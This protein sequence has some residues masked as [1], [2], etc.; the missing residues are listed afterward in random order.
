VIIFKTAGG[1]TEAARRLVDAIGIDPHL[2][3]LHAVAFVPMRVFN[4]H[5]TPSSA[6]SKVTSPIMWRLTGDRDA[7]RV[8]V[9]EENR[10]P[11]ARALGAVGCSNE[12]QEIGPLGVRDKALV[13]ID[14]QPP[15]RTA[16]VRIPPG[17]APASGSVWAKA[18]DFSPR[19]PERGNAPSARRTTPAGS[20]GL[21]GRRCRGRAPAAQPF[22]PFPR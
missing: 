2:R 1:D 10:K 6:T 17:S 21:P 19:R 5:L 13:A 18:V 8:H 3:G 11:A 12:L 20:S 7:G 15:S 16:V 4:R 9:D 14:Q 22:A